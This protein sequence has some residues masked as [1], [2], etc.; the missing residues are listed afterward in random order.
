MKNKFNIRDEI[1]A[2]F[3][4]YP[5]GFLECLIDTKSLEKLHE[6]EGTFRAV[7]SEN[8]KSYYV[9]GYD[10]S[11]IP[12]KNT[13]IHRFL[14]DADDE[15]MVVDHINHNTLD[16]RLC[17]LRLVSQSINMLNRDPEKESYKKVSGVNW[18]ENKKKWRARAFVNGINKHI[19]YFTDYNDAVKAVCDFKNK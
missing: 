3:V 19:G 17:N 2:V 18:Y 1:T 5:E 15:N 16:N 12:K 14:M 8:T 11:Y 10:R 7:W 9:M 4:S 6:F 13:M